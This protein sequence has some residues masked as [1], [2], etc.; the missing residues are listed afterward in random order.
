MSKLAFLK[1]FWKTPTKV[2]SITPSGR[3]LS[4]CIVDA[5]ELAPEHVVVELGAGTGPFTAE[6]LRRHA[7]D[8]FL[9]LEPA[10]DL[11]VILRQRFPELRV[12]E[13]YAQDLPEIL[14]DWGKPQA[15]RILSGLPFAMWSSDVQNAIFDGVLEAMA[16]DGRFVTFTYLHSQVMP[17]ARKLRRLLDDRFDHVETSKVAWSNVPPAFVYV[18]RN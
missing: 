16:P 12:E 18:C 3:A 6:V 2:G 11:A 13:R 15:H 8:Q 5:C 17:G 1:E 14:T 4:Q 9:A 10:A 7:A